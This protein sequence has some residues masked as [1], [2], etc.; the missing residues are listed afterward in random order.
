MPCYSRPWKLLRL[1]HLRGCE[2]LF[3]LQCCFPFVLSTAIFL[4]SFFSLASPRPSSLTISHFL[5]S[6]VRTW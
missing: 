2:V 5:W 4:S 3:E 1:V 6:Q